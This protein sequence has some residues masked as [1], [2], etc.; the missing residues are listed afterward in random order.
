[1]AR[2][3]EAKAHA[4]SCL[5]TY[6][7]KPPSGQSTVTFAEET[8]VSAAGDSLHRLSTEVPAE[9]HT[10]ESETEKAAFAEAHRRL[11]LVG[12]DKVS[13]EEQD[14]T[15]EHL[16]GEVLMVEDSLSPVSA[17]D[18]GDLSSNVL[19]MSSS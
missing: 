8:K 11:C 1:M 5:H 17:G 14:E 6:L 9:V 10:L 2:T 16:L 3:R 12:Y 18:D 19:Q 13:N 15:L 7:C 4:A